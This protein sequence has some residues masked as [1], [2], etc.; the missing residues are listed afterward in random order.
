MTGQ[1]G[2]LSSIPESKGHSKNDAISQFLCSAVLLNLLLSLPNPNL[3]HIP[4]HI[5]L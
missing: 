4:P 1:Y 5:P 2:W 3:Q